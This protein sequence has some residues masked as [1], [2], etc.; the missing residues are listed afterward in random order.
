[1]RDVFGDSLNLDEVVA[2]WREGCLA[3]AL[4]VSW[5]DTVPALQ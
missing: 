5:Q 1:M 2:Q 4:R 3:A